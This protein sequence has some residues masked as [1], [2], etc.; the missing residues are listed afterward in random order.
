M[1]GPAV[2]AGDEFQRDLAGV[3]ATEVHGGFRPM[4]QPRSIGQ[5][6][7]IVLWNRRDRPARF[8]LVCPLA[9]QFPLADLQV[10][11]GRAF[12]E[13]AVRAVMPEADIDRGGTLGDCERP[14]PLGTL[15]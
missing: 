8:G 13:L 11:R 14:G 10:V 5:A 6:P 12:K 2:L 9:P 4:R 1:A 15:R 3:G 7:V